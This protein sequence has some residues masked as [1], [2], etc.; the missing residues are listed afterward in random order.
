MFDKIVQMVKLGKNMLEAKH[1][2]RKQL[3]PS[4]TVTTLDGR[5]VQAQVLLEKDQD[6]PYAKYFDIPMAGADQRHVDIVAAGPIDPALALRP[7]QINDLLNPGYLP[8]EV[9]YC[10]LPDGTGYISSIVQMPNV[11]GA[12]IDWW[13]AWH[14]LESLRYKIWNPKVHYD[15]SVSDA[16]RAR[17]TDQSIPLR[18]RIWGVVQ[19]ITEDIGLGPMTGDLQFASPAELGFDLDR[20]AQHAETAVG[21]AVGGRAVHIARKSQSGPGIELR[22][23][24]WFPA[25]TPEALLVHLNYHALEEYTHMSN[26][27]PDLYKEFGPDVAG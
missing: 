2:I 4:K 22:T 15:I 24:F 26:I 16:D 14:P 25:G 13:F 20:F 6:K 18:E 7:E 23:R 21:M 3:S 9:G 12:M 17:L 27:L 1:A 10:Y 8:S 5:V 11:T 19:H